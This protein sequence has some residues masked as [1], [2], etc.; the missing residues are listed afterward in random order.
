MKHVRE[1]V[2]GWEKVGAVCVEINEE[3]VLG[4]VCGYNVTAWVMHGEFY[5][6][7]GRIPLAAVCVSEARAAARHLGEA[8]RVVWGASAVA[9]ASSSPSGEDR[10]SEKELGACEGLQC[11]G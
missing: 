7:E 3:D 10:S 1:G 6:T 9:P 2:V 8:L 4:V 5:H 11:G